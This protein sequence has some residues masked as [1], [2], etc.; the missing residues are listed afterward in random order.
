MEEK[1]SIINEIGY[2]FLLLF[3]LITNIQHYYYDIKH[4]NKYY[5]FQR[6]NNI[7]NRRGKLIKFQFYVFNNVYAFVLEGKNLPH[8]KE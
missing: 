2:I 6:N 3:H 7:S 5:D 4:N 8:H 1:K